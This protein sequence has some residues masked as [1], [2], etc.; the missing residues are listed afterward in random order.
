MKAKNIFG[1]A[2]HFMPR[3]LGNRESINEVNRGID[4]TKDGNVIYLMTGDMPLT[5]DLYNINNTDEFENIYG[6]KIIQKF[7]NQ[8]FTYYYDKQKKIRTIKKEADALDFT[9][10]IDGAVTWF[11]VKLADIDGE[12]FAEDGTTPEH[13]LIFSDSVGTWNDTERSIIVESTDNLTAGTPNILKDFV[14]SIQ[15]SLSSDLS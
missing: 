15:D 13:T 10:E 6:D 4:V 12:V 9:H 5:D 11:C 3:D 14:L 7:E 8:T 2:F 1:M